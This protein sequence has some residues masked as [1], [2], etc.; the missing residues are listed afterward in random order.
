MAAST[1]SS[2]LAEE[3]GAIQAEEAMSRLHWSNAFLSAALL[4][5][6][7]CAKSFTIEQV[8]SAPFPS[9]LTAAPGGRKVAWILNERG[10]RNI[11]IASAPDWKGARLTPYASDNGV[12]I[13]QLQWMPDGASIVYVR[14]GDL[15]FPERSGPNPRSNP[16]GVGQAIWMI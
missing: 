13:G 10:L 5:S 1:S 16:A 9:Q 3:R 15:E 6:I 14:G 7:A 11:W 12:D 8:L 4:A 2:A